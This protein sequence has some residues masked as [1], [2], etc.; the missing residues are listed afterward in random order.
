MEV[1]YIRDLGN[2]N[3]RIIKRLPAATDVDG[4]K[5]RRLTIM[6]KQGQPMG[7]SANLLEQEVLQSQLSEVLNQQVTD[8][9]FV[10]DLQAKV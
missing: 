7:G 3:V 6:G 9:G 4:R 8:K 1:Y 2:G 5:F 10:Y